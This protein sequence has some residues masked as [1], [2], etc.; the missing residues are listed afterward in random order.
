[1]V[2]VIVDMIDKTLESPGRHG[3]ITS[4]NVYSNIVL[5]IATAEFI[6]AP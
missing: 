1:M 6:K 2:M 4:K 5:F 3:L